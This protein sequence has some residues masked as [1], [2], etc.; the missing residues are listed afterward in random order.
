MFDE[1][2]DI[3]E[4]LNDYNRQQIKN[5][6]IPDKPLFEHEEPVSNKFSQTKLNLRNNA[7]RYSKEPYAPDQC[8]AFTDK[9]P[10]GTAV[11]P[12]MKKFK[13]Y[14]QDTIKD[15]AFYPGS[16]PQVPGG[17]PSERE[18]IKNR[19]IK[20]ER[21]KNKYRLDMHDNT[22]ETILKRNDIAIT[23]DSKVKQINIDGM[24]AI[25]FNDIFK[26]VGTWRK[27]LKYNNQMNN[28]INDRKVKVM[29]YDNLI[30][31]SNKTKKK[32]EKENF[33]LDN[34]TK[35][36]LKDN[37]VVSKVITTIDDIK[38]KKLINS[39]DSNYNIKL[40]N[41]KE[42]LILKTNTDTGTNDNFISE[43]TH[44]QKNLIEK[45]NNINKTNNKYNPFMFK[46]NTEYNHK[47]LKT[48]EIIENG[49]SNKSKY[50]LD[51][52]NFVND[53]KKKKELKE[54]INPKLNAPKE[55]KNYESMIEKNV[56][57]SV[58]IKNSETKN[59]KTV[60][61]V[62]DPN[63]IKNNIENSENNNDSE[64]QKLFQS[65]KAEYNLMNQNAFDNDMEYSDT[66]EY[67]RSS[68]KP[69]KNNLSNRFLK[70]EEQFSTDRECIEY[71][72]R[73][74]NKKNI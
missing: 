31:S 1:V 66:H 7:S 29:K 22:L 63:L 20:D 5:S 27:S 21:L 73:K 6:I 44:K 56:L 24:P 68:G 32:N 62:K 33:V 59:Y 60:K 41:S 42:N 69:S 10:R 49:K 57:N 37:L 47:Q 70:Q 8:L 72:K 34:K 43:N 65:N 35:D 40:K 61:F 52:Q 38:N 54:S 46:E 36:E 16:M 9:D 45:I 23:N 26:E 67:K 11:G 14:Y 55:K 39:D 74:L 48:P 58:N 28:L 64:Y 25:E 17:R 4:L 2:Y 12:D 50:K 71:S 18:E 3:K 13:Y 51:L 53:I 19:T 30:Q 15:K